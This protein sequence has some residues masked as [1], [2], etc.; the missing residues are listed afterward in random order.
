MTVSVTPKQRIKQEAIKL[1]R[2]K[3]YDRT[4]VRDIAMAVGI[5][6]GSLFHHFVSKEAILKEAFSEAIT[7]TLAK[8]DQAL[9]TSQSAEEALL[10]LIECELDAVA[11]EGSGAVGL[12]INEWRALSE[13]SQAEMLQLRDDYEALWK[14]VLNQVFTENK[15]KLEPFI[16]RKLLIGAVG[17]T[18]TWYKESGEYPLSVIA[19]QIQMLVLK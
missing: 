8:M 16:M 5:Q 4:T 14:Q 1:F 13:E 15:S 19:K 6:S 7:D 3:G 12:L 17:W 18:N 11:G 9:S 2:E 10:I